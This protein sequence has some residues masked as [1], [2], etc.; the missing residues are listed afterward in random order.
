M[1]LKVS[2]TLASAAGDAFSDA[3]ST[4]IST[5]YTVDKSNKVNKLKLSGSPQ[6]IAAAADVGAKLLVLKNMGTTAGSDL[7]QVFNGN[8]DALATVRLATL[9][10]G[11]VAVIPVSGAADVY[12]HGDTADTYLE[13]ME[14]TIS[15]ADRA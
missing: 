5:S 13:I 9:D 2:V 11:E 12:V 14:F 8:T 4:T 6:I 10:A 3:I 1:A 7:V 15:A